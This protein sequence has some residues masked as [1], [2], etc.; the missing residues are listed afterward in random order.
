MYHF[1]SEVRAMSWIG[2]LDRVD[3]YSDTIMTMRY[4]AMIVRAVLDDIGGNVSTLMIR[5]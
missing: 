1:A 5:V 2:S 3:C 4:S